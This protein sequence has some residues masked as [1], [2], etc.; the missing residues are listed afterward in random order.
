MVCW[1]MMFGEIICFVGVTRF[2]VDAEL[3][4]FDS[5]PQP[6]IS[7]VDGFGTFLFDGVVHDSIGARVI[8]LDWSWWLLVA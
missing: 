3:F 8:R 2:P 6:I 5:V 1:G 7:H 4:L